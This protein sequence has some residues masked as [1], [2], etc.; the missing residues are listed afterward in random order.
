MKRFNKVRIYFNGK[1][2]HIICIQCDTLNILYSYSKMPK[3]TNTYC[4]AIREIWGPRTNFDLGAL[5]IP[6][7]NT[8]I[9]GPGAFP[10]KKFEISGPRNGQILHSGSLVD[11]YI[12]AVYFTAILY[13][14][15]F[16][17]PFNSGPSENC[18]PL[19][20]L[21]STCSYGYL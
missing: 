11:S 5:V 1:S 15:L 4:T 16:G 8:M 6:C 3:R 12:Y 14:H 20:G 18:T 21:D 2:T 13:L 9:R 17:S 19:G 7:S 10:G